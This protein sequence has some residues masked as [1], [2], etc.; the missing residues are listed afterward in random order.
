MPLDNF[1]TEIAAIAAPV[2]HTI[3]D[4][5][6]IYDRFLDS[7]YKTKPQG[8]VLYHVLIVLV[9]NPENFKS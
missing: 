4:L 9:Y 3:P 1:F 2:G 8:I 7:M 5:E 6:E